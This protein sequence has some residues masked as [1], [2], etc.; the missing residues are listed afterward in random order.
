MS[1]AASAGLQVA[2][3]HEAAHSAALKVSARIS[4]AASL[5][6]VLII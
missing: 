6:G 5:Y 3:A 4:N 1:L 2:K